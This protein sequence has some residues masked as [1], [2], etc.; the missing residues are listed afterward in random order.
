ME[1]KKRERKNTERNIS[2]ENEMVGK[3]SEVKRRKW[4]GREAK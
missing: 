3:G 1:G 4:N 2:E